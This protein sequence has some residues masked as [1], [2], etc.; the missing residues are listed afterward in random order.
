VE[1]I[2]ALLEYLRSKFDLHFFFVKL[3]EDA[4]HEEVCDD[5]DVMMNE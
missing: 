5:D 3:L 2:V 1:G 4:G